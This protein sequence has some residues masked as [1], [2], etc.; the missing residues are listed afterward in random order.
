MN[1]KSNAGRRLPMPVIRALRLLCLLA[2]CGMYYTCPAQ[3]KNGNSYEA[4]IALIDDATGYDIA[5]YDT[6]YRLTVL[7]SSRNKRQSTVYWGWIISRNKDGIDF[8]C[9]QGR[10]MH[11][12]SAHIAGTKAFAHHSKDIGA[13]LDEPV[14]DAWMAVWAY[15]YLPALWFHKKERSDDARHLLSR[16]NIFPDSATIITNV[17]TFYFDAMLK[18]YTEERNYAKAIQFGIHL[19]KPVFKDYPY[20]P[21][22]VKLTAQLRQHPDDFMTFRL[23]GYKAWDSIK[24]TLNRTGQIQFLADRLRLIN[25]IQPGQPAGISY[26]MDQVAV[27][28]AYCTEK[29][30]CNYWEPAGR[31]AVLNPYNE[32]K[33]MHLNT[34][35]LK[36]LLPSMLEDA[37]IPSYSYFRN[38][39]PGRTLHRLSWVV[40]DLLFNITQKRFVRNGDFDKLDAAQQKELVAGIAAW[41]DEHRD[42][43]A[44]GITRQILYETDAWQ[45]FNKALASAVNAGDSVVVPV[46]E[47]RFD[48]FTGGSWPSQQGVMARIMFEK[49]SVKN[50][51]TVSRWHKDAADNW[52]VLWTS[53]FL[54]KNDPAAHTMAMQRL[55]ALLKQCDGTTY[56]P[57]VIGLLLALPDP[58]ARQ[59][60]EGI[61]AKEHFRSMMDWEYYFGF[62]KKLLQARSDYTCRFLC[63][64]LNGLKFTESK[65]DRL[66]PDDRFVM[67]AEQLRGRAYDSGWPARKKK[68][69]SLE[70]ALWLAREYE[71]Y[72]NGGKCALDLSVTNA[73][74]PDFFLD[75]PE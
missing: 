62:V 66:Y 6:L 5:G 56:Y 7:H 20:Q 1:M 45:E 51:A 43:D 67:A 23:P 55:T 41:C 61:L 10:E 9:D 39:A 74:A 58:A 13:Y 17:G 37:Y 16:N 75:A 73:G 26:T 53:L 21:E 34:Q 72:K 14:Y 4:A 71:V 59:L 24:Q 29:K 33:A 38:F 44:A 70:L 12:A 42:L 28:Y 68:A 48:D 52:V 30:D 11:I 8:L 31:Y 54:M 32:L 49:G 47:K 57:H 60:A 2:C 69:Y 19:S 25:C 64:G 18:A 22:I 27:S 15:N 40:N 3:Q 65:A 50:N 36:L 35:E 46:L 63:E